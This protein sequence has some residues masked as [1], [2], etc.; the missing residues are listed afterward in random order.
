MDIEDKE[1]YT[2]TEVGKYL[3]MRATKVGRI[4]NECCESADLSKCG[5]LI[6]KSGL[7]K[8]CNF[9]KREMNVI[10]SGK[11]DL[12]W[13][14]VTRKPCV[15]KQ[16]FYA[17]DEE[18]GRVVN[19]HCPSAHKKRLSVP[20]QRFQ[21]ERVSLNAKFKYRWTQKT[22]LLINEASRKR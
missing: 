7:E 20:N 11:P 19:V 10:E 14:K 21:V 18:R 8:I 5:R 2:C 12:A 13:V 4:K 1:E 15:S 22:K 9:L 17:I 6:K 16:H 3:D